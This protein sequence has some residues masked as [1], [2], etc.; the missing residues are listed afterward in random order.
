M[1][2]IITAARRHTDSYRYYRDIDIRE[3]GSSRFCKGQLAKVLARILALVGIPG[4][5][6]TPVGTV[7]TCL[8]TVCN[9]SCRAALPAVQLRLTRLAA[10][11]QVRLHM[12]RMA[13]YH[14]DR[15][16]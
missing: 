11:D 9:S 1:A 8:I 13:H 3:F 2:R 14:A 4:C 16:P 6:C 5:T 10:A 12:A 7:T 15:D